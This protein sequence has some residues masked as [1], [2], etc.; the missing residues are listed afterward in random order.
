MFDL[1]CQ[2]YCLIWRWT[3]S[4]MAIEPNRC[5]R[6]NW[7]DM[8][9]GHTYD[10]FQLSTFV[11]CPKIRTYDNNSIL[12]N[13][14][15]TIFACTHGPF[16]Q[17]SFPGFTVSSDLH[18]FSIQLLWPQHLAMPG[19][20]AQPLHTQNLKA[21]ASTLK[22]MASTAKGMASTLKAMA[23][24][25]KAMAS[26]LKAMASTL[27][28]MASTLKATASTLKAMASNLKAMASTLNSTLKA[29]A[30]TLKATASTPK[31]WPPPWTPP[32]KQWPPP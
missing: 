30:S 11:V 4:T 27:K 26:T 10:W 29:M 31:R 25:L 19:F 20:S 18:G 28:A 5:I 6:A 16:I 9:A 2:Y 15:I 13:L 22:A 32:W 3:Y 7:M 21:M 12:Y 1:Y 23:S 8:G 14:N 24:T 17:T